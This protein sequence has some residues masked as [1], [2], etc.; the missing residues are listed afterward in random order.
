MR[1]VVSAI[2][3]MSAR[4]TAVVRAKVGGELTSVRFKEGDEVRAGQVLAEIDARSYQAALSQAWARSATRRCSRMR[5]STSSVIRTCWRA[6]P[7]PAS[8]WTPRPHWCGS[9]KRSTV[10][11]DQAQVDAARTC[12]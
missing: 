5:S 12:N 8:R 10:A 7:S 11:S 6:T 2:G 9:W 4:A 3:T 1:V